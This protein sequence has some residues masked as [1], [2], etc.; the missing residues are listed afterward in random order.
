MALGV[1]LLVGARARL[2]SRWHD[3]ASMALALI[4]GLMLLTL[5]Y[6]YTPVFAINMY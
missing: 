4:V 3:V 1:L 6:W 2:N 5:P